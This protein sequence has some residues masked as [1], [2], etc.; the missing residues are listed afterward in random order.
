M[1]ETEET[2]ESELNFIQTIT[3]IIVV[4][5]ENKRLFQKELAQEDTKKEMAVAAQ[6]QSLLI[7]AALP[8]NDWIEMSALY[9][10]HQNVGGDY[11]DAI[12]LNNNEVA[13]CI[14]DVSGK[15]MSAALL[16]PNFQANQ[17][18]LMKQNYELHNII[19]ML[20]E[21]VGEITKGDK[22]I[23]LFI[24]R[25]NKKTKKLC[26]LNAGRNPPVLVSGGKVK[27]LSEGST[28]IGVF[29]E[30]PEVR[31]ETV[32]I[33]PGDVLV[34]YTDG[35][36]ELENNAEEQFGVERVTEFIHNNFDLSAEK[37]N[38]K[39]HAYIT[40]Y[41]EKQPFNDDVTILTSRF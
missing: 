20:N 19:R 28:I 3:N 17:R 38:E 31:M 15:G 8:N 25:Y 24:G 18:T 10:P 40:D 22:F 37:I 39:L 13:F 41:K 34:C 35:L 32:S 21:R 1:K 23:T 9:Q 26:Y 4:A 36:T 12:E 6:M 33:K 7:P 14:A 27:L 2:I 30:L 16:M 5:I 29:D 11:Y